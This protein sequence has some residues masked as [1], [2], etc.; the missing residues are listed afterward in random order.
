MNQILRR[1][2]SSNPTISWSKPKHS[3]PLN[4]CYQREP[5]SHCL[6]SLSKIFPFPNSSWR[7]GKRARKILFTVRQIR[8]GSSW[9]FSTTAS[10]QFIGI[11]SSVRTRSA[12][13]ASLGIAWSNSRR[14]PGPGASHQQLP[15]KFF[16]RVLSLS[17]TPPAGLHE[18][19]SAMGGWVSEPEYVSVCMWR[20]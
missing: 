13:S 9:S 4:R 18:S 15:S 16:T 10:V 2:W 8:L 3:P 12:G 5:E 20:Y 6:I 11:L 14:T 19:N 1:H 7:Y 17:P